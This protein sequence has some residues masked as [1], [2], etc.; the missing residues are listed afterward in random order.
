MSIFNDQN[1]KKTPGLKGKKDPKNN[2][3]NA[4]DGFFK[5]CN[6]CHEILQKSDVDEHLETC[7]H[8]GFHFR[9]SGMQRILGI[10]DTDTFK[11]KDKELQ[12]SDPLK[13]FDTEKY[14]DRIARAKKKTQINEALV[15]GTAKINATHVEIAAF[16]FSF[17]G[18]SM[19]S[20]VGEKVART[21]DRAMKR[22]N[23]VII[24]HS[25]GGARMQEGLLSLMQMVKCSAIINQFKEKTKQ[26][27]ISV[28]CDPTTG[29]VAASFAFQGDVTIAEPKALIGFAGPRVIEQTIKQKLPEGFQR[30]EFLLEHG[31]IDKI[32]PRLEQ[33]N[34][35]MKL[36]NIFKD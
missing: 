17:M 8:C 30:S 20:I 16:E 19:G 27:Y 1:E 24:F 15:S 33:R 13:F 11:E 14:P 18:G 31:M 32:V 29:G 4:P 12:S 10:V 36:L 25:T 3:F 22:N 28:L 34:Y 9:I 6:S 21:F 7:S 5:K 35:F 26:P 2:P 23:P